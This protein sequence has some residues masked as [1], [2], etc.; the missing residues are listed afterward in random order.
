MCVWPCPTLKP[1]DPTGS[2]GI[3]VVGVEW[4]NGK[5]GQSCYHGTI[6][7]RAWVRPVIGWVRGQMRVRKVTLERLVF[8]RAK[9]RFE[10]G[11]GVTSVMGQQADSNRRHADTLG[12][13][14]SGL[15]APHAS[16]RMLSTWP[17]ALRHVF[18]GFMLVCVHAWAV[19]Q[20][21]DLYWGNESCKGV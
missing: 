1:D 18:C 4:T 14:G 16:L 21:S 17:G 12:T 3:R 10:R 20:L 13:G 5:G 2:G 11:Q 15:A 19:Y 6:M 9:S 7:K 8:L